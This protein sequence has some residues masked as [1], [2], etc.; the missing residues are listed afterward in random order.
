MAAKV[1]IVDD[2]TEIR[3]LCR[4][5]LEFEGHEV[6]EAADGESALRVARDEQPDVIFLDL[7]MPRVDGWEVLGRLKEDD[8]TA[9]I[10]VVLLTAKSG[11][12][13]QLRGWEEG[14]LQYVTKPFNPLDLNRLVSQALE[15]RDA[16]EEEARRRVVL[17]E[18]RQRSDDRRRL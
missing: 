12:H 14:I 5:N 3:E 10:P 18:L 9:A 1:L 8:A 16:V 11:E 7:M 6:L 4:V 13:D 17:D 15:P 2:E